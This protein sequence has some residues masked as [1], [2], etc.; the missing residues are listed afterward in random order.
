MS[1]KASESGEA[2]AYEYFGDMGRPQEDYNTFI[3]GYEK[4]REAGKAE[5]VELAVAAFRFRPDVDDDLAANFRSILALHIAETP[6]ASAR[7]GENQFK[8][9]TE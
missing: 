9:D 8:K 4:G 7:D 1:D 5:M 6:K 3:A 2:E